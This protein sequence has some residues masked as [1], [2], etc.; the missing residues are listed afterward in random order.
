MTRLIS[1]GVVLAICSLAW[2]Q[3]APAT[4][5]VGAGTPTSAPAD[6]A[7]DKILKDLEQAG[8]KYPTLSG[9]VEYIVVNSDTEETQ[10]RTGTIVYQKGDDKTPMKLRIQ[11]DT[12]KDGDRP[13]TKEQVV[14]ALDGLWI[15]V[16]KFRNKEMTRYQVAAPGQKVDPLLVG[17]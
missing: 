10:T 1:I 17:Q 16:M 14:Y 8:D 9:N 15:T 2:S 12:R 11:F 3:T 5:P 7:V 4:A 6:P 13:A